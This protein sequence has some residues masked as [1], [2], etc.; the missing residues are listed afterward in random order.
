MISVLTQNIAVQ[1]ITMKKRDRLRSPA[2]SFRNKFG[3]LLSLTLDEHYPTHIP[4]EAILDMVV[5]ASKRS[6]LN[7]RMALKH[8]QLTDDEIAEYFSTLKTCYEM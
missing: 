2:E 5:M 4:V 1:D 7:S 3:I 8:F 6:G